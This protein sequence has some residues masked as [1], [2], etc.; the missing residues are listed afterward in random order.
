MAGERVEEVFGTLKSYSGTPDSHG[1]TILSSV[2]STPRQSGPRI[3]GGSTGRA[4]GGRS[5]GAANSST[6][7][8]KGLVT[9]GKE[10]GLRAGG[11]RGVDKSVAS[12][13]R[14]KP[15]T[16]EAGCERVVGGRPKP[17]ARK[18]EAGDD[19]AHR[20]KW[21]GMQPWV[22]ETTRA[23]GRSGESG[24]LGNDGSSEKRN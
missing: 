5:P 2:E 24:S 23:G 15:G 1:Q 19:H 17:E 20:T 22:A 8:G 21:E 11:R 7:M 14:R 6:S 12:A 16:A 10:E 3:P 18:L 4:L 9:A 13:Q